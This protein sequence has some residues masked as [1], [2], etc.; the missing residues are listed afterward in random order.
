MYQ[1]RRGAPGN[2]SITSTKSSKS[3]SSHSS[4]ASPGPADAKRHSHGG[5]AAATFKF[6]E[7]LNELAKEYERLQQENLALEE[8]VNKGNFGWR[9][10]RS[11]RRHRT[12]DKF[13]KIDERP[14]LLLDDD[15]ARQDAKE[16]SSLEVP[17]ELKSYETKSLTEEEPISPRSGF[18]FRRLES[19]RQQ[20][21]QD[22]LELMKRIGEI[23]VQAGLDKDDVIEKLGLNIARS[24]LNKRKVFNLFSQVAMD[25]GRNAEIIDAIRTVDLDGEEATTFRKAIEEAY[26]LLEDN[27]DDALPVAMDTGEILVGMDEDDISDLGRIQEPPASMHPTTPVAGAF[28]EWHMLRPSAI[29]M[30]K[31]RR[32]SQLV[33]FATPPE[34]EMLGT[35]SDHIFEAV[36]SAQN[37]IV[38]EPSTYMLSP[39]GWTCFCWDVLCSI[40]YIL[41]VWISLFN[42]VFLR[43]QDLPTVAVVS[44][45]VLTSLFWAG[46]L[47]TIRTG[48]VKH[49]R[50]VMFER[51][52][53]KRYVRKALW[54]DLLGMVPTDVIFSA[55]SSGLLF[56]LC[57][58][59]LMFR[60]NRFWRSMNRVRLVTKLRG[61]DELMHAVAVGIFTLALMEL[62][63]CIWQLMH[64]SWEDRGSSLDDAADRFYQGLCAIS[65]TFSL[66]SPL[67][68][69]E[70]TFQFLELLMS[71]ERP[72]LGVAFCAWAFGRLL[73]IVSES[74]ASSFLGNQMASSNDSTPVARRKIVLHY[75]WTRRVSV[76]CRVKVLETFQ[77][78][79]AVLK[80]EQSVEDLRNSN[81]PLGLL[82]QINHELWE[83]RLLSLALIATPAEWDGGFLSELVNV[84][85][86]SN[87]GYCDVLFRLGD[88]SDA[89]YCV[90][91]GTLALLSSTISSGG[92]SQPDFTD[93][94]WV[95]ERALANPLMRRSLTVVA[96]ETTAVMILPSYDFH[97]ILEQF[98]FKE[99][100]QQWCE[101][102]MHGICGRCGELGHFANDCKKT[103]A[104][105]RRG[106][107][108]IL[109][110]RMNT[111]SSKS[112]GKSFSLG[113][114]SNDVKRTVSND[115]Q[116][117]LKDF[118]HVHQLSDLTGY[119]A[120]LG[121]YELDGLLGDPELVDR[122][123]ERVELSSAQKRA[124]NPELVRGYRE[125]LKTHALRLVDTGSE[126][127]HLVF[128]SHFKMEA[129]TEAALM[130]H[131][132][133]QML[134]EAGQDHLYEI[135]VFLDSENLENLKVLQGH[136][137]QSHN[138]VVLLTKGILTRPWCL[139][140]IVTAHREGVQM[141]PVE[142]VK[143]GNSFTYPDPKFYEEL[144]AGTFLDAGA[145]EIITD[146]GLTLDDVASSLKELFSRISVPFSP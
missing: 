83:D 144:Q 113:N 28:P 5:R 69:P 99:K 57:I 3:K 36:G 71:I 77:D 80:R 129:G 54:I 52:V 30:F 121:I 92:A 98:S 8:A 100:F 142:V 40:S 101:I 112:L 114:F 6:Q 21:H 37:I 130:R 140:E 45:W 119:L 106:K 86:E 124:L 64:P 17:D 90:I 74:F 22:A 111:I 96:R 139:V 46:I 53:W 61:S 102:L 109:M 133:L 25:T 91:H 15:M 35:E 20:K 27:P 138:L 72:L 127:S 2:L 89:A 94:M 116:S 47:I 75:L 93:N 122:L 107:G 59:R 65:R 41:D 51:K 143:P 63:I 10:P 31:Q 126:I 49:H 4:T 42:I 134:T 29:S 95:G 115:M 38:K 79:G 84:V 33:D 141:L 76:D 132:L 137:R 26:S 78:K 19:P 56:V 73:T 97:R 32:T 135:P 108:N 48:Y 117:T 50:I 62:H 85:Q 12:E 18:S 44:I 145:T 110:R 23:S 118:L 125:R 39:L 34:T 43:I 66:G 131:E 128:L 7:K 60:S 11:P 82:D 24:P 9:A 104:T 67:D 1:L 88:P 68:D 103:G 55:W 87:F 70:N 14:E 58:L 105:N 120:E 123:S 13:A 146:C 81:L 136:V 16:A